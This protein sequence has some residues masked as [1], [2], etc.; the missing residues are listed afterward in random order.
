M[1]TVELS[2]NSLDGELSS[3]LLYTFSQLQFL[4][5]SYNAFFGP[6]PEVPENTCRSLTTLTIEATNISGA[7]PQ[8][9]EEVSE[10]EILGLGGNQ[11]NE[12]NS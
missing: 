2:N 9:L 7:I 3:E 12:I 5:L 1:T 6:L 11:L 10:L 8:Q 4:R